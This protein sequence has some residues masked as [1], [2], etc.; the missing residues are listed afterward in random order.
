MP[1]ETHTQR[2]PLDRAAVSG[3]VREL[4]GDLVGRDA[5]DVREDEQFVD[6]LGL[7]SLGAVSLVEALEDELGER[8]VGFE[9]DD[10]DLVDL[11]TVGE[12]IDYVHGRLP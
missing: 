1:A 12:A 7:D 2:A 6:D 10:D 9:V 3:L 5:D 11:L 4:V 8:S